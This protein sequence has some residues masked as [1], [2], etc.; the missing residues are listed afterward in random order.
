MAKGA[1]VR[2]V[3]E[4][5]AFN[6]F[7]AQLGETVRHGVGE[8]DA[9]VRRVERW[10]NEDRPAELA[11][12]ERRAARA[13]E[14]TTDELRRK[15]MQPTPTGAP[16]STDVERRQQARARAAA[17]EVQTLRRATGRWGRIFT[18][19]ATEYAGQVQG[20][21]ELADA[22]VPQARAQLRRHLMALEAYLNTGSPEAVP[23]GGSAARPADA[24][25]APDS[26]PASDHSDSD[27][28]SDHSDSDLAS[29]HSDP[30]PASDHSDPD[31]AADVPTIDGA[32]A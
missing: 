25:D 27:L 13:V 8:A 7:L 22:R 6:A 11:A 24:S 14:M 29:D 15:R 21:R 18:A 1:R 10:L 4:L 23:E 28:A 32:S 5:A 3:A 26:D 12:A 20:A 31:P 2:S 16:P 19:E 9:E 17:D 30:D